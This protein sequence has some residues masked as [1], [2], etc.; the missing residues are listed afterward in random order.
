MPASAPIPV[1]SLEVFSTSSE[2]IRPFLPL[3]WRTAT[4][5]R[6]IAAGFPYEYRCWVWN[7]VSV[8]YTATALPAAILLQP[9]EALYTYG[10]HA[11]PPHAVYGFGI[12]PLGFTLD[13]FRIRRVHPFAETMEG[14][15]AS[16]EPI[17]EN[18]LNA[19]GLNFLFDL[20]G[21]I[22]WEIGSRQAALF[23]YRF[24]HI[25]N[26]G[27]TNFNPGVDNNIFYIGYSFSH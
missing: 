18:E 17:P 26:A 10:P 20:G 19:S 8:S 16:S 21:G 4:N 24:L 12:A 13:L 2:A 9:T 6:F 11:S 15:I 23:G 27:T 25:S 1:V 7:S 14:L 3:S 22:R 5:R